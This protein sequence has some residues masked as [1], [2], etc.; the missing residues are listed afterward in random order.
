MYLSISSLFKKFFWVSRESDLNL[1][2]TLN[3]LFLNFHTCCYPIAND[4]DSCIV[5]NL[6]TIL[7]YQK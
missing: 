3:P 5:E 6:Q 4:G 1:I 2:I 7:L